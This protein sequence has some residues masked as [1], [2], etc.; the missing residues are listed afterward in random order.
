MERDLTIVKNV[1]SDMGFK[2]RNEQ[3]NFW[4]H[5]MSDL[6]VFD[7]NNDINFTTY[8]ALPSEI[9]GLPA[10]TFTLT[11]Q[12][13]QEKINDKSFVTARVLKAVA[14]NGY[15]VGRNNLRQEL[16]T[17]ITVADK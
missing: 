15:K 12:F 11:Y 9:N 14:Q 17:L 13:S 6:I 1:L 2:P 8:K 10:T 4:E 3:E 7:I 16:A 5:E